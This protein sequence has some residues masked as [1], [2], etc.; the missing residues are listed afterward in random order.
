MSK[1]LYPALGALF[2]ALVIPVEIGITLARHREPPAPR[3]TL[4][5]WV[6]VF[7]CEGPQYIV[8]VFSDGD[9][10]SMERRKMSAQER[11]N[12]SH[13]IGQVKGIEIHACEVAT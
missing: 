6:N 12:L 11:A 4:S 7:D 8:L 2:V 1:L 3:T 5:S 10:V 13:F 9:I